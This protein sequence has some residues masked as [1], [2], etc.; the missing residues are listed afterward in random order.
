MLD[1]L[2]KSPWN[3]FTVISMIYNFN[4]NFYI[5]IYMDCFNFCKVCLFL[6]SNRKENTQ[7]L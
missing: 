1:L 4:V 5:G 7:I 6:N 3:N 2:A